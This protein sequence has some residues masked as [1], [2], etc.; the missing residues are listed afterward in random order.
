LIAIVGKFSPTTQSVKTGKNRLKYAGHFAIALRKDGP[1]DESGIA[2]MFLH[3]EMDHG[4]VSWLGPETLESL[5]ELNQQ[6]LELMAEQAAARAAQANLLLR[7]IGEIWR[8]LDSGARRRAASCPYLLVDAGFSDPVRWRWAAAS[9]V[10]DRA[11]QAHARQVLARTAPCRRVRRDHFPRERADART[12]A[13]GSRIPS[14]VV[15]RLSSIDPVNG[16]DP[17]DQQL[18]PSRDKKGPQKRK[19]G[20]IDSAPTTVA[21]AI[22]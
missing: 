14:L 9:Q 5:V 2:A 10:G 16:E 11:P 19:Q 17:G 7:Q 4:F 18:C 20:D 1:Q 22:A 12:A 3:C 6:C 8:T 21:G 15:A 13:A